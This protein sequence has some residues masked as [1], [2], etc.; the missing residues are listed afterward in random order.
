MLCQEG[1][2]VCS[3]EPGRPAPEVCNTR[4][5]DCDGE[6]DEGLDCDAPPV[7]GLQFA[8]VRTNL[9]EREVLAGGFRECHRDLYSDTLDQRGM[10][11]GC[12][13]ANVLV[14]CREVGA[15]TFEAAAMGLRQNVFEV[16]PCEPNTEN[17]H[18]GVN[19][20]LSPN[21]SFGFGPSDEGLNRRSCDTGAGRDRLCW[22]TSDNGG[23]RCGLE[24]GLNRSGLW[25][26]IV[27]HR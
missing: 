23:Y 12:L 15:D 19:W 5:D 4:D 25:E 14:A 10:L 22:H 11:N 9:T 13:R 7:P 8:G 26:R 27:Y 6:T 1:Q 20:Y 3:A 2:Q 21:C 18:N 16:I 24:R 17:V